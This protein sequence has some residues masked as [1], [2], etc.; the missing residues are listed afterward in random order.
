MLKALRGGGIDIV[1]IHQHMTGEE[2]RILFLHYWGTGRRKRSRRACA[3]RSTRP[4]WRS[5]ALTMPGLA[6][7]LLGALLLGLLSTLGDFAWARFV[8]AHRAA[9]GVAHGT[10]LLAAVGLY[11]GALRGRPARGV[12]AGA[13]VGLLAAASFYVLAPLL[14]YAAMLASWMALWI[15]FALVDARLRGGAPAREVVVRGLAAAVGSGL[16]FWAI[17]RYLAPP[18]PGRAAL[19]STCSPLSSRSCR[20]SRRSFFNAGLGEDRRRAGC[21]RPPCR[22]SCRS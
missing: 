17:S 16:A 4:A 18:R 1:A 6:A 15:G 9:Y 3:P 22:P 12:L 20:V 13:L 14:G 7:A 5:L 8:P 2:P 19:A 11:L 21:S 10:L